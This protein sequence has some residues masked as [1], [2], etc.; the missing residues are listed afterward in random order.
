MEGAIVESHNNF[1]KGVPEKGVSF[2]RPDDLHRATWM[3]AAWYCLKI[4]LFKNEF[5]LT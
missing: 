4:N 5:K 3:A 2:R 1:P